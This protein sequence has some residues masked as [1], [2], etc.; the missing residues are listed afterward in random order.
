MV[1]PVVGLIIYERA[2][3]LARGLQA[4]ALKK[5]RGALIVIAAIK[6][7]VECQTSLG[8]R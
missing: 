4:A 2:L 6:A 3:F 8:R 5:W 1:F 7:I